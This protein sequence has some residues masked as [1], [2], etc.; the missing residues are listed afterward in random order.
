MLKYM[1]FYLCIKLYSNSTYY[2]TINN[3]FSGIGRELADANVQSNKQRN[4][5]DWADQVASQNPVGGVAR[6]PKSR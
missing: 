6:N 5:S 3:I 4:Q 1:C 2:L